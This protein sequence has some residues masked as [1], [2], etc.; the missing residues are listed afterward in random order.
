MSLVLIICEVALM[1]GFNIG[2]QEG[3][4][5]VLLLFLVLLLMS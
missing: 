4:V 5:F 3:K 2:P 1:K